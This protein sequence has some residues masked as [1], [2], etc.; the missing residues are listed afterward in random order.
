MGRGAYD[1][2]DPSA[3]KSSAAMEAIRQ[4]DIEKMAEA[5]QAAQEEAVAALAK[6]VKSKKSR[7]IVAA[8]NPTKEEAAQAE[9]NES[10]AEGEA[11]AKP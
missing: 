3:S 1:T 2:T 6:L 4:H 7:G 9:T 8:R 11:T 10:E 5:T